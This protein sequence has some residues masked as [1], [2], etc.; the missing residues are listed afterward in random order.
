MLRGFSGTQTR[1][2]VN[3][4]AADRMPALLPL[5]VVSGIGQFFRG[6]PL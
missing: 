6:N 4:P 2:F 3:G 5:V 1:S